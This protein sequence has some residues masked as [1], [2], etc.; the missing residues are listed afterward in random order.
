MIDLSAIHS[1]FVFFSIIEP[2]LGLI[3][4]LAF[5]IAS[6]ASIAWVLAIIRGDANLRNDYKKILDHYEELNFRGRYRRESRHQRYR[7]WKR[8]RGY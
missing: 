1:Q 7:E 8:K 3:S 6:I 4:T 5:V 2:L